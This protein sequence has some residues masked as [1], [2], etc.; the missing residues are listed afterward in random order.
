[1]AFASV[2]P[3]GC[4]VYTHRKA[5]TGC[6]FY[7]GKGTAERAWDRH[8]RSPYWRNVAAKH[9]VVV[10]IEC[11]GLFEF[12]AY[13]RERELIAA[14]KAQG[15]RLANLTDGGE[16]GLNPSTETREKI[17]RYHRGKRKPAAQIEKIRQSNLGKKRSA[18][19]RK[20]ISE[21]VVSN[22]TRRKM[23]EAGRFRAAPSADTRKKIGEATK[24]QWEG[25]EY[26]DKIVSAITGK[27][28][29]A[30]FS[31]KMSA[32]VRSHPPRDDKA[33]VATRAIMVAKWSDPDY[34]E[35]MKAAH[36]GRPWSEARRAAHDRRKRA[37]V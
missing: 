5:T 3:V 28:R 15:V 1:M 21:R 24:K 12:E 36:A 30:E 14:L 2:R 13:A 31:E 35:R 10:Q 29:S 6:I 37:G 22:E 16:G 7:V 33:R 25:L 19:T 23:S 4:Y 18:E 11:D 32:I 17:G 26:R 34:R 8:G 9:G 20:K 27:K